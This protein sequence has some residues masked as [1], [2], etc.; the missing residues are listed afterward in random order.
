MNSAL[1]CITFIYILVLIYL[2]S[3]VV[4]AGYVESLNLSLLSYTN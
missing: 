2:L 3:L 1:P 4:W